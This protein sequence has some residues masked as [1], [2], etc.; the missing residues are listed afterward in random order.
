M[1]YFAISSTNDISKIGFYPQTEIVTGFNVF[2]YENYNVLEDFP[3]KGVVTVNSNAKLTDF[4]D[5]SYLSKGIIVNKKFIEIL[6][7]FNL[8]PFR[9]YPIKTIFKEQIVEYFWFWFVSNTKRHLDF[10]LSKMKIISNNRKIGEFELTSIDFL[11]KI[12]SVMTF[13]YH[14]VIES[15]YL[16]KS[17]LN[18]DIIDLENIASG[19]FLS[20]RLNYELLSQGLSGFMTKEYAPIKIVVE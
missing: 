2:D 13:E 8:P 4:L 18:Y 19:I 5:N 11:Q 12:N 16:K 20:E 1:K 10:N 14:T 9:I 15:L 6:Q 17:F 3:K 7:K